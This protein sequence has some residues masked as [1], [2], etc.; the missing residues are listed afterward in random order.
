MTPIIQRRYKRLQEVS[1]L[2]S[3]Q[4]LPGM[5]HIDDVLNIAEVASAIRKEQLRDDEVTW[6]DLE[7]GRRRAHFHRFLADWAP[8][9]RYQ[10]VVRPILSLVY[11]VRSS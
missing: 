7:Q 2:N 9:L 10:S 3:S 6:R 11:M 8:I 1:S 5:R 4:L